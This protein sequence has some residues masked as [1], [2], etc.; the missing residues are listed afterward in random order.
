MLIGNAS[1]YISETRR[2]VA[3]DTIKQS[4]LKLAKFLREICNEDLGE[5]S[6]D[7]FG[8]RARQKVIERANTIEAFNKALARVES[9][10]LNTRNMV[11]SPSNCRF[12][13]KRPTGRYGD[14][15]SQAF[16]PYKPRQTFK[17]FRPP[18]SYGGQWR[19]TK[20]PESQHTPNTMPR[21]HNNNKTTEQTSWWS[22]SFSLPGMAQIN[23]QP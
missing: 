2:R 16:T 10:P 20:G 22:T 8:P 23:R 1:N 12:L 3:I 15:S 7:L 5:A 18:K 21:H 17:K 13:S 11:S 19:R 9:G 4:R 14:R 6:G